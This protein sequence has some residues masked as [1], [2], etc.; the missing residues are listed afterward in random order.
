MLLSLAIIFIL[1]LLSN[2]LFTIIKLPGFLGMLLVGVLA[3][4]FCS[5]LISPQFLS[6]ST[7]L[8][9]IA[10]IIIL[11]RAGLNLGKDQLASVG[12]VAIKMSFIP[13]IFEGFAVAVTSVYILGFSPI[14]GGMLGFILAAVSP[15]VVIPAML[16]LN[17]SDKAKKVSTIILAGTS[18]ENV[19]AITIFSAFLG[20]YGKENANL[21]LQIASVPISIVLGII[22][23]VVTGFL[24]VYLSKRYHIRDTK[25]VLIIISVA[26]FLTSLETML[27]NKVG[28]ASLLGVMT[29]GFILLE[30]LPVV[31]KRLSVKFSKIWVIAE[32]VRFVLVG[33]QVNIF[34]G[35]SAGINGLIII[36]IGLLARSIGV[37][38]STIGHNLTMRER[39]FCSIAYI[40]KATVQAAIG[41]IPLATGVVSGELMLSIAVLAILI[42]APIGAIG[43]K[44]GSN[45]LDK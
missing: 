32:I 3:G 10:L 19:I 13:C 12:V 43:I 15:A 44:L 39:L 16:E 1:G 34:G 24:I 29:M 8:R 22:L 45:L 14:E 38:I 28:V 23:G 25:K 18:V 31:A 27:Q 7:D 33:A 42:T 4:P 37:I 2:K 26:I 21:L 41:A 11:L 35:V 36:F 6:L 20:L 5:N 30:K 40:P 17:K 9:K